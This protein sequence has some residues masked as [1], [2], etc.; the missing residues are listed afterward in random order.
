MRIGNKV[1]SEGTHIMGILNV[2]PDSF[3]FKSRVTKDDILK[4][5]EKMIKEGAAILDIGAQSTRPGHIPVGPEE[6]LNRLMEPLCLIRK[7]FDIPLSVDTYN[8]EVAM[9]A[10]KAGADMIND[11]WGL[12]KD[13]K[14]AE[15]IAKY[16]AAVC[17]MHN[18][19]GTEYKDIFKD[20][21][22]FF[23]SSLALCK[24]YGIS[25]D[26]ICLDGGIG[27]GKTKEQNFE[28]LYG[29]DKFL[30]LGFPLLLG[31]SRKSLFGG[32]VEDRLEP[33]LETTRLAA[34][35]GVLFVRVHD[36]KENLH[37]IR[38]T[39]CKSA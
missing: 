13:E 35:M 33:T 4:R 5:A 8:S 27:F 32:S 7:E 31:T 21:E 14:M 22:Q 16:D 30:K 15:V 6:E 37:A 18:Q 26:K 3:Y 9:E 25:D 1:F 17:I 24:Q 29:Y 39:L 38:E 12:Q 11:I 20:I 34:K 23:Q 2:T 36:V 28:V 19:N 10:L